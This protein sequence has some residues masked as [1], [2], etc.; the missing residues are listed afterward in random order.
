MRCTSVNN[1]WTFDWQKPG[2]TTAVFV[3]KTSCVS[4]KCKL[5]MCCSAY[6]CALWMSKSSHWRSQRKEVQIQ[7]KT[8]HWL[9]V[10]NPWAKWTQQR[11]PS[12]P[13]SVACEQLEKQT[14]AGCLTGSL[15]KKSTSSSDI[16]LFGKR[17]RS[18]LIRV[19]RGVGDLVKYEPL[20]QQG[21]HGHWEITIFFWKGVFEMKIDEGK[22][23]SWLVM[24]G[25]NVKVC[26]G[27]MVHWNTSK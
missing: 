26:A 23:C 3:V 8:S 5:Y 21:R 6:I 11:N 27:Q 10:S 4:H 13:V 7:S 16:C 14:V 19:L 1:I 15:I 9:I 2:T 12:W 18:E 22:H 17:P 20:T 24:S 25:R